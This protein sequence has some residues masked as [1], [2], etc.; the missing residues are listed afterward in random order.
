MNGQSSTGAINCV[1]SAPTPTATRTPTVT[2]TPTITLTPTIT[3]TIT[4]TPIE[5]ATYKI[6]DLG[7]GKVRVTL[8]PPKDEGKYFY[9]PSQEFVAQRDDKVRLVV[10]SEDYRVWATTIHIDI[11]EAYPNCNSAPSTPDSDGDEG[12]GEG[13]ISPFE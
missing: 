7:D 8:K 12:E 4:P 9:S 11:Y 5:Y 6:C 2:R 3:P 13:P 1:L 10:K